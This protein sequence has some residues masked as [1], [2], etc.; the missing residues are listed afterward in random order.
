MSIHPEGIS[1]HVD[2]SDL[3]QNGF[4]LN[5]PAARTSSESVAVTSRYSTPMLELV[6]HGSGGANGGCDVLQGEHVTGTITWL[7]SVSGDNG[8]GGG[9]VNATAGGRHYCAGHAEVGRCRLKCVESTVESAWSQRLKV[10][11]NEPLS[12]FAFNVN[13]RRYTAA[14]LALDDTKSRVLEPW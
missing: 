14:M 5:N 6:L 3:G 10:E 8:S 9:G 12:S 7:P 11:Y 2:T 13:L 1:R 4:V